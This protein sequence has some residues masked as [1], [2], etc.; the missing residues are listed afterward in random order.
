MPRK[1]WKRRPSKRDG[2]VQSR[3]YG[4]AQASGSPSFAMSSFF[5]KHKRTPAELALKLSN[6]LTVLADG[7]DEKV[8]V[9][10]DWQI[11]TR[12]LSRSLDEI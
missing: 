3:H 12:F 8:G 9:F 1:I 5:K 6:A 11:A 2:T 4:S 7:G 10:S